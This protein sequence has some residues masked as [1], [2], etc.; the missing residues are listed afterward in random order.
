MDTSALTQSEFWQSKECR[1]MVNPRDEVAMNEAR[2]IQSWAEGQPDLCGHLFFAT[3]GSSGGSKWVA[4][5]KSAML[6]SARMV[7]EHLSVTAA[8]RWLLALPE[9]HVGGMGILARCHMASSSWVQVV[10]KWNPD[11]YYELLQEERVTLSSLVPTQLVDLVRRELHAPSTLRAVL[12]GGGRLHDDI[13][14]AARDLGWPVVETYGMTE[15]SS[16]VATTNIGSRQLRLLPGWSTQNDQHGRLLVKGESLLTGYITCSDGECSVSDPKK[17]GWFVTGDVVDVLLDEGGDIL[18][19]KGRADRCLKIMGEL[20]NLAEVEM[21]I[22]DC[23]GEGRLR[24]NDFAVVPVHD[25]RRGYQ[26]RLVGCRD[27]S[28]TLEMAVTEFNKRCLPVARIESVNL[29]DEMPRSALGKILYGELHKY[30]N[31]IGDKG[32]S[33]K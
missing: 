11:T 28:A 13:F 9:F 1:V 18:T 12:I 6:S 23:V 32:S 8:D 31:E 27:K 26:L 33:K 19:V 20:V 29:L 10:G 14:Q 25:D 2:I 22:G 5:S 4:L 17:D 7:N 3:S 15:T 24:S 21:A 30:V 16:Q